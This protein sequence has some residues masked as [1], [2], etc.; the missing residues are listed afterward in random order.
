MGIQVVSISFLLSIRVTW[1]QR[2]MYIFH[3]FVFLG[4]MFSSGS[5]DSIL[6]HSILFEELC[7]IFHS[8]CI[9]GHSQKQ[10]TRIPFPPHLHLLS[11]VLCRIAILS[12]VRWYLT[13]VLM[14]ISPVRSDVEHLSMCLLAICIFFVEKKSIWI[15]CPFFPGFFFFF[16]VDPKKILLRLM[17]KS[18]HTACVFFQEF[19][20]FTIRLK[21]LIPVEFI[22]VHGV[23]NEEST[24]SGM[25]D[26][27]GVP[28]CLNC[29]V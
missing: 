12:D 4:K 29:E 15:S 14:S 9:N 19:Y 20:S 18:A 8:S 5:Q 28:V 3:V 6:F 13:V 26:S 17:S 1:T 7:I 23:K 11:I 25:C 2:C 27:S 22:F 24:W 10:C 21:S 16:L